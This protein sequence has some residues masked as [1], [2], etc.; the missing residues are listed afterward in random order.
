MSQSSI[1][2]N[3]QISKCLLNLRRPYSDIPKQ[4]KIPKLEIN[5]SNTKFI[6]FLEGRQFDYLGKIT[7]TKDN[8]YYKINKKVNCFE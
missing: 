7:R 5:S 2:N 4:G 6:E 8:K 1:L 3:E